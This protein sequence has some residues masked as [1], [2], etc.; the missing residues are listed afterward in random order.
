MNDVHPGRGLLSQFVISNPPATQA[1]G[2]LKRQAAGF[3]RAI[4]GPLP[5][6]P[7]VYAGFA[8]NS[9]LD[10]QPRSRGFDSWL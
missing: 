2:V 10:E 8:N 4:Y 9:S 6:R 5:F 7:G 3:L 1:H